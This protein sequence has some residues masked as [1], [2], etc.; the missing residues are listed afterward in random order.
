MYRS[1]WFDWDMLHFLQTFLQPSDNFLDIGANT[2]LHTLLASTKIDPTKGGRITCIEP[3]PIN[4][5]RLLHTLQTNRLDHVQIL[6][7]AA[8]D[9]QGKMSLLGIDVFAHIAP[10]TPLA[11][12]LIPS[13]PTVE[14]AKLDDIIP[15]SRVHA[16]KIDVEGAEWQVLRGASALISED[17]LPVLIL[18]L[19]GHL[20]AYQENES[21]FITWLQSH[22]YFLGTYNH[23]ALTLTLTPPYPEDVFALTK[24]GLDQVRLRLPHVKILTPDP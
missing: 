22:G 20:E 24:S 8:T 7:V 3:H 1:E 23:Q 13:N 21:D 18:E 9:T 11:Q 17:H 15:H 16:C 10:K 19:R 12:N 4:L 14:T 5:E 2:G 6:P